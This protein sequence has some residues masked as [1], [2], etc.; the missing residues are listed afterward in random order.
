M[1]DSEC[2]EG[3]STG[4][5]DGGAWAWR[6]LRQCEDDVVIECFCCNDVL[7]Q[8]TRGVQNAAIL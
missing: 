2:K 1:I 4:V 3:K 6:L 5:G 8:V 7:S